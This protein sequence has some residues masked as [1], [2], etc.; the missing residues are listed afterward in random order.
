MS[1]PEELDA[2]A[3]TTEALAK[4]NSKH[5]EEQDKAAEKEHRDA[6]AER[7]S[8]KNTDRMQGQMLKMEEERRKEFLKQ[9]AKVEADSEES[10]KKPLLVKINRYVQTFTFL[11]QVI[12]KPSARASLMEL[13]EILGLIR[14]E[15]AT[16]GANRKL[17]MY[18]FG[19][20]TAIEKFW[21]NGSTLPEWVPPQIR[22]MDLT[23]LSR[24]YAS[25]AF[26]EDIEPLI[27]EID[28]E[29]PWIGRSG[30]AMRILGAITDAGTKT[31]QANV[32][33]AMMAAGEAP[34]DPKPPKNIPGLGDL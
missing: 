23:N 16:H 33:H 32:N 11:Q 18:S 17:H 2:A 8:A 7:Q 6:I 24:F 14:T 25:G 9:K 3:F 30:L 4:R 19:I 31:A 5:A 10:A 34:K 20:F 12:P 1:K 27:Q 28:I 21:G 22:Q 29:Y 13:Q 26:D 15:M